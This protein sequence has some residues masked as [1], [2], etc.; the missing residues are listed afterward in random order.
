MKIKF[1]VEDV[2]DSPYYKYTLEA[3]SPHFNELLHRY[4][5]RTYGEVRAMIKYL[6]E[7]YDKGTEL[8]G[9]E[10]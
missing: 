3:R 6:I 4:K 10:V 7:R 9:D 5:L 1:K 2:L 8:T